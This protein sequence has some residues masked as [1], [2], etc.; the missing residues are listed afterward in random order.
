MTTAKEYNG[1]EIAIIGMSG[2][3]S[4]SP[5]HREYWQNLKDGRELIKQYTDDELRKTGMKEEI[6][7]NERYIRSFGVLENKDC[8]DPSFFGYTAEEAALMDP[9]IRVFHE[10][11]WNALEDAGYTSQID[12]RKIGLFAGASGNDTWKIHAHSKAG[13]SAVDPFFLNM[14]T[15][16]S[17]ISTLVSYKLNLRGPSFYVDTACSTSLAAVHLACRSLLTRECTIALAGGVCVTSRKAKGYFYKEGMIFSA[18]G[19]CRTFDAASSGT[20]A[21]EG[22]GVVVL[23]RL[24]EAIKDRDHIYAVIRSTSSNNDGNHK[25]GYT[26]PGVKGQ[27]ECIIAA[28]KLAGIDPR[29][30]SY[31]EAHGTATKLGDQIEI[32]ALNEAFGTG[33]SSKFCAIGSVKTNLG[34]LD[35]AAGVAG[36]IKTALSLKHKKIP[37]SLHFTAPN[38]E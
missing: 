21:G 38:P 32:R 25:V 37:A 15:A 28:H 19:H 20:T 24:S 14:I 8:F 33:G 3:F 12:K 10:Q 22:A 7:S 4:A 6:L 35:T 30:I 2:Q 31:V 5:N 29:T 18:D 27:T 26:A 23:K 11:C 16:Q 1:L 13:S 34:H 36:L 17:F 9:Q